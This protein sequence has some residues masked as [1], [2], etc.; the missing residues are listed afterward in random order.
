MASMTPDVFSCALCLQSFADQKSV[1]Q[2][3]KCVS[4]YHS[5]CA[6]V[7]MRGFHLR[8]LSWR[9]DTCESKSTIRVDVNDKRKKSERDKDDQVVSEEFSINEIMVVLKEMAHRMQHELTTENKKLREKVAAL[10]GE[11]PQINKE[12]KF[13]AEVAKN[14]VLV[15]KHKEKPTNKELRKKSEKKKTG[16]V[17]IKCSDEK[18]L[19]VV[20]NEFRKGLKTAYNVEKQQFFRNCLRIWGI[21]GDEKEED[22][23]VLIKKKLQAKIILRR[24][25]WI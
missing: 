24:V 17:I 11:K 7:E 22:N 4:Y 9:C 21:G 1:V 19:T 10:R 20:Q 25:K 5:N 6:N 23:K 13:F 15:V 3:T 12:T 16:E 2:C 18:D 14:K 8:K